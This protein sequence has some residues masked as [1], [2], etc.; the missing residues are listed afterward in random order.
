MLILKWTTL[1]D[2]QTDN[3]AGGLVRNDL[4]TIEFSNTLAVYCCT[5]D[6]QRAALNTP[7]CGHPDGL[8]SLTFRQTTRLAGWK[9]IA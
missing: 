5:Q 1:V 6:G 4:M 9:G 8:H 3:Q 7:S 2:V